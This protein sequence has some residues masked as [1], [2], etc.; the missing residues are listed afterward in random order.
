MMRGIIF[1]ALAAC[2][3]AGGGKTGDDVGGDDVQPPGDAPMPVNKRVRFI[4][5]GDTGKG[6]ADQRKVAVAIRDLCAAKGCDF[7]LLLGDN[8]YDAGVATTTDPQWQQKFDVRLNMNLSPR[9]FQEGNVAPR[10]KKLVSG[11][12]IDTRRINIEITEVSQIED[13][14]E[15]M[16]ILRELKELG[17]QL[18]L[19]DFGTGHSTVEHL[20]YF[21]VDGLKIPSTFVAGVP[22]DDRSTKI[23]RA[24]LELAHD[25][26]LQVI[27]EGVE[28]NEQLEFLR[29]ARCDAIQGFLFSKPMPAEEF[30]E[31]LRRSFPASPLPDSRSR[32]AAPGPRARSS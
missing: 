14:E 6:N 9:E 22:H 10:L 1:V 7:V 12:G 32:A 5:M 26:G 27:A 13:P 8:I 31:L 24:L 4:A 20:L 16:H 15:T 11:C 19:D 30:E 2:S 3:T 17:M 25:L 18:W 23:S 28:R 29:D 21:P